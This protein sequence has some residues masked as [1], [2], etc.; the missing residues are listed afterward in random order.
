MQNLLQE[1][2]NYYLNKPPK[3][4]RDK[5]KTFIKNVKVFIKIL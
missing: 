5:T 3:H 2:E 4:K 1:V